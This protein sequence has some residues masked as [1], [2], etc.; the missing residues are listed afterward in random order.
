MKWNSMLPYVICNKHL[1]METY[2]RDDWLLNVR[3]TAI[4]EMSSNIQNLSVVNNT[5]LNNF[6]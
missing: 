3:L 4:L 2:H 5:N 1:G 6:L